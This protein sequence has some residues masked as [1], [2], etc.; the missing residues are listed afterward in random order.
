MN[1]IGD[2]I[3]MIGLALFSFFI[4]YLKGIEDENKNHRK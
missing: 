1:D 3:G 2:F 4:G